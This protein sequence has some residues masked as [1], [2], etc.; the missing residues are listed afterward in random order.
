MA[1]IDGD[2]IW[3]A[4]GSFMSLF[5]D[6]ERVYLTTIWEAYADIIADLWGYAYQAN[7]AKGVFSTT[8]TFERRNVL[9][10]TS[11]PTEIAPLE[12]DLA[13]VTTD[14][15]GL[16]VVR[17]FVARDLRSFKADQV[18]SSGL[19]R[20]GVDKLPYISVNTV[21]VV[22][23]QYDGFVR[24]ATFT[25][26]TQPPHDYADSIDFNDP[27]FR[28]VG[29]MELRIDQN[30]GD[31]FI[32]A[33][34]LDINEP[35]DVNATG[36]VVVG[37][38]GVNAET[39]E[40]QSVGIVG[41]RYVF[42]FPASWSD[43]AVARPDLN[44]IHLQGESVGVLRYDESRWTQNLTGASRV[45]S[46]NQAVL[47]IDDID[48][49]GPILA[50][51]SAKLVSNYE[52]EENSDFDI[53][54][55]AAVESWETPV[56]VSSTRL[57][58]AYLD[59]GTTSVFIGLRASPGGDELVWGPAGSLSLEAV[60]P[61]PSGFEA[62]FK[63]VGSGLELQYREQGEQEFR[64]LTTI[65][66]TGQRARMT[67]ALE[68]S[69]S[70][71]A[72]RVAFDEALRRQ[73]Q[74]AGSTRLETS[75]QATETHPYAYDIDQNLTYAS[76]LSDKPRQHSEQ[77]TVAQGIEDPESLSLIVLPGA[78]F[79]LNGLEPAGV[80]RV[81]GKT[82][83]YDE[84]VYRN[85]LVE[86]AL[87]QKP[88]PD[89]VPIAAGTE[90]VM[91]PRQIDTG[92]F[93]LDGQG[94]INL[95]D[96]PT[97]DRMWA[98]I[99]RV[100]Y[101]HIQNSFGKLVDLTAD[102][103]DELYLRRV[104]GVW[105][106]L[107][108]GP[109][110]EN[111]HSGLQ[112]TM[113][114]PVAS[115]SG[116][117]DRIEVNSDALGNILSRNL[118]I[119][120]TDG[121]FNHYLDPGI[122]VI[123]FLYG[124]G[125]AIDRFDPLT[126]GVEVADFITDPLWH[127]RLPGQLNDAERFNAFAV[128]VAIEAISSASSFA[129]AIDFALRIKGSWTKIFLRFVLLGGREDIVIEEDVFATQQ[130]VLC[131]DISFDEGPAPPNWQDP[132]RFGDGHKMGQGKVFGSSTVFQAYPQMGQGLHFG[133]GLTFGMAPRAWACDPQNTNLASEDLTAAQVITFVS[134]P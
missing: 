53:S 31:Q 97:R 87:R 11:N 48:G 91:A 49:G 42:Y 109:A 128:F 51:A 122:P 79:E 80:I 100:D 83:I 120:N 104:Q 117:V 15:N 4:L 85:S 13:S 130:A 69:G 38:E 43:P 102:V 105:H 29:T 99:A 45:Y 1:K 59:V 19:I 76:A 25:L 71:S 20:I 21:T 57:A 58:G 9:V 62:R 55:S 65:P 98:P 10:L 68:D 115:V 5:P 3:D 131:E 30:P 126:D 40:Y 110:I 88:D 28:D 47:E 39:F 82:L 33:V 27:F 24:E 75:F 7:L 121:E 89:I 23:G 16:T 124:P 56:T 22:G 17:G 132:L 67:L 50:T 2:K 134:P 113:G 92:E 78:D 34:L 32:D 35:L 70:A 60:S 133:T 127:Q 37:Q 125:D 96:P 44:F 114:L 101:Q 72:S 111:V 36:R 77:G 107:F 93:E 73:G 14:P 123:D 54:V 74:V 116:T 8:P 81:D 26:E 64:L 61:L 119:I 46:D 18:P 112:L 41:D 95:Q 103:S 106:A 6:E 90:V 108:N 52:M 63:R 66:V 129:D 118:I 94:H 12:F 86:F 84:Y